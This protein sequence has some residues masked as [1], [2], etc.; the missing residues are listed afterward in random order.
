[1]HRKL[2]GTHCRI[3]R[4]KIDNFRWRAAMG[5]WTAWNLWA[6]VVALVHVEIV[7]GSARRIG[8][9][10][11]D[12]GFE[13]GPISWRSGQSENVSIAVYTLHAG[14]LIHRAAA[15]GSSDPVEGR[16]GRA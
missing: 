3:V 12:A 6:R 7:V 13:S 2:T 9:T 16:P 4:I 15:C 1:M 5:R 14:A 8:S 10:D 11:R